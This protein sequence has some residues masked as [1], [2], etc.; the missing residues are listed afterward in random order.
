M[1]MS[2]RSAPSCGAAS[3]GVVLSPPGLFA[4]VAEAAAPVDGCTAHDWAVFLAAR[5]R[6]RRAA[7][8]RARRH[9]LSAIFERQHALSA[10]RRG[11]PPRA[12]RQ[13]RRPRDVHRRCRDS[14]RVVSW[15]PFYH[16][17]GL[18]GCLLSPLA[19]Q[20][21]ADYIATDDFAR[22][23]LSWLTL[24]GRNE[25]TTLSLFADLRLRHLRAADQLVDRRPRSAS[26]C[27][28]GASPATAPT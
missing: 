15:L 18:V 17:M 19:N 8:R 6:R 12:A 5:R 22:R 1:P 26:T 16:D 21:S 11:D 7:R 24:I 10:R 14:D 20:M 4:L 27:R 13:P 3:R 9:R 25:G 28:A 2:S 23:P